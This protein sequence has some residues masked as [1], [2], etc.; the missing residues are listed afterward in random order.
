MILDKEEEEKIV[1]DNDQDKNSQ[2]D[3]AE[4]PAKVSKKFEMRY[5]SFFKILVEKEKRFFW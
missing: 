1:L 2:P 4:V 3:A 5:F